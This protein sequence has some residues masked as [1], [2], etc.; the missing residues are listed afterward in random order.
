MPFGRTLSEIFGGPGWLLAAPGG[1][2]F[3]FAAGRCWGPAGTF[4]RMP[5]TNRWVAAS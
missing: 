4:V 3:D 2:T 1:Q 5:G